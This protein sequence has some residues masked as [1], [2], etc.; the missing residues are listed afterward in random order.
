[1]NL[2][3]PFSAGAGDVPGGGVQISSPP[4]RPDGQ[5]GGTRRRVR[6]TIPLLESIW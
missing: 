5:D 6:A 4:L 1:M 3:G 2:I